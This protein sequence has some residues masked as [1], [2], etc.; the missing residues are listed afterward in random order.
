MSLDLYVF[1]PRPGEDPSDTI[2]ALELEDD[3]AARPDPVAAARNDR[4]IVALSAAHPAAREHRSARSISLV[5]DALEIYLSRQYAVI[6]IDY[7]R[8]RDHDRMAADVRHAAFVIT[9]ATGWEIFD[10]SR[11]FFIP[12]VRV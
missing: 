2:E 12:V 11:E 4:I 5:D 8:A 3:L 10:T 9:T 1:A 7:R 6:S